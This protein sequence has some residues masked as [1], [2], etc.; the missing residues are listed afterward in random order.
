MASTRTHNQSVRLT[1]T[2]AEKL[3]APDGGQAFYR[4]S[5]VR[6]FG[7]RVT[8]AGVRSFILEL[9][10][11][12]KP[13]R[14]TLGRVGEINA[15]QARKKAQMLVGQIADGT[16]PIEE[17]E[18]ERV[19]RIT[20]GQ[21]FEDF[22]R[23]RA[24]LKP[25]TLY[26]YE[27]CMNVALTE[28]RERPLQ[29]ITKDLISKRHRELGEKSGSAYANSVMRLLRSIFSFAMNHYEDGYGKPVFTYNPVHRLTHEHAWYRVKRRKTY[30]RPVDLPA[31]YTA[32]CNLRNS[33]DEMAAT[34][35]DYLVLVLFT[36]LRKSE[37]ARLT[38][39]QVDL[40]EASLRIDDTKNGDVHRLPV[41]PFI[42]ELLKTRKENASC[43]YVFAGQG[44]G[45]YLIE[46][47][48]QIAKVINESGVSFILHDLRRT[49]ITAAESIDTSMYAIKR[50][51]NHRVQSDVTHG[52][53]VSD[54]ERLRAPMH[55]IEQY[56]LRATGEK[57]SA[58]VI[59]LPGR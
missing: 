42:V 25:R 14:M 6:G 2:L 47:K 27:R 48:R 38:W 46:P 56:L 3:P 35:A 13:R 45:G 54:F 31:W 44:P 39:D 34:V 53:I 1:Q 11:D 21:V 50:L 37:A 36:G 16:N 49:F 19:S 30:I 20:L 9:R 17:Q 4:D 57:P 23:S 29:A 8:K 52:Y 18:R 12:G 24:S 32:V 5:E 58:A 26:D 28:W 55:K 15:M 33:T 43:A 7:L 59:S 40:R 22:K 51:V 41:G 10:I